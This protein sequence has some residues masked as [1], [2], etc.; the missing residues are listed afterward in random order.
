MLNQ[1]D[2]ICSKKD[3]RDWLNYELNRYAVGGGVNIISQDR[4]TIFCGAIR[5]Y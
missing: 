2:R 5:F 3:M 4:N 1:E